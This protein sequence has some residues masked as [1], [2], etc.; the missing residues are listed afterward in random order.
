MARVHCFGCH[1]GERVRG[2]FDLR[3]VH[4]R[5]TWQEAMWL[6]EDGEMPG[7]GTVLAP[8]VLEKLLQWI[9]QEMEKAVTA[10]APTHP[11]L[12]RRTNLEWAHAVRDRVGIDFGV[13]RWLEPEVPGK[14]GFVHDREQLSWSSSRLHRT[15]EAAER[16]TQSSEALL[17][18]EGNLVSHEWE[19]ED[20]ERSTSHL[21]A[22]D[23]GVLFSVEAQQISQPVWIPVDGFYVLDLWGSTMGLPSVVQLSDG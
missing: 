23:D 1:G 12:V 4:D 3:Q 15:L 11:R 2:D 18:A 17:Q 20:W 9:R 6:V 21:K 14:T 7:D 22:F 19:A 16:V 10:T 5:G 13:E 8:E